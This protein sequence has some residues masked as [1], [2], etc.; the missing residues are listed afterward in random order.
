ML[1]TAKGAM[2]A[3][4][5]S[6][7]MRTHIL[8]EPPSKAGGSRTFNK[9]RKNNI[10]LFIL[11]LKKIMAINMFPCR[12]GGQEKIFRIF[13]EWNNNKQLNE[14]TTTIPI[15]GKVHRLLR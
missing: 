7:T 3:Y 2:S 9:I 12:T 15:L 6:I 10:A 14:K 5:M 13:E 8:L 4:P 1:C 11:F